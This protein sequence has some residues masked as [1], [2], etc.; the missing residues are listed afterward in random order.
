[1]KPSRIQ[2]RAASG[3]DG[4]VNGADP[5][6]DKMAAL[7]RPLGDLSRKRERWDQ[8]IS[9][10]SGAGGAEREPRVGMKSPVIIASY[11]CPGPTIG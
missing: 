2:K 8:N 1:M 3:N 5:E 10:S 4:A 7:T 9:D 11:A 6:S